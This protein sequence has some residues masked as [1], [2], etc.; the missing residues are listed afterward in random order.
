M[1]FGCYRDVGEELSPTL[2]LLNFNR[3]FFFFSF[4][5]FCHSRIFSTSPCN[6][7]GSQ[8]RF[9]ILIR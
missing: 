9:T 7:H 2:S 5:F 1:W 4:F 3:F 6:T 8:E